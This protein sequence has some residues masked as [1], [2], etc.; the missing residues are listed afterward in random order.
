MSTALTAFSEEEAIFRETVREFASE[1]LAPLAGPMD[2]EGKLDSRV[3]PWLFELGL[4][5]IEIPE[6]YGGAGASFFMA[7]LAIEEI[8]RVDPAVA[9][10]CD[11]QNT[12]VINAIRRWGSEE[13]KEKFFGKLAGGTVGAYA[14]S[15]ASSG[16]DAFALQ[17]HARADGDDFVLNGR[18]LWI[19]NGAEAGVFLVFANASP[20]EGYRGITGFVVERDM[21]GF[22]VGKKEDKLG[23]RASSTCELILEDVRVP[24]AN[25]LG[26][27]GQGYKVAIE[28]LNEGR[29]GIAS[30]MVGLARGAIEGALEY[31]QQREQFGRKIGENQAVQHRLA[32][33]AAEVE[34]A[35]LMVYNAARLHETGLPFRHQA[36]MA[37][38]FASEVAERTASECLEL[39]GGVG[40][41][42]EC[43]AEKLLRDS[44][45]GKIYEGTSFLQ[46]E[47]IAKTL[48]IEGLGD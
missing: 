24:G 29:I 26:K 28:T 18:K 1:K 42:K 39:Y 8:A 31:V 20:D 15:E 10:V 7:I 34:A 37:K 44:K 45:I 43:P 17:C 35:R 23:I 5:A 14:L 38:W 47:T 12:L 41:T 25:V 33:C 19:T 11:V 4:M 27:V 48:M 6:E 9:V 21:A 30:Q 22:S 32:R 13:Q 36:A 2:Q 16:S 46:L 40:F 3:V